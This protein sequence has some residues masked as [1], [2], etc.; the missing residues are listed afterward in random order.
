[1]IEEFERARI[2]EATGKIVGPEGF[3]RGL[4]GAARAEILQLWREFLVLPIPDQPQ[5]GLA[6]PAIWMGQVTNQFVIGG[7]AQIEGLDWGRSFRFQTINATVRAIDLAFVIVR[8]G[9]LT[10]V[11]I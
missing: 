7:F 3:Q 10:I 11:P 1:M 8:V 6:K 5:R 2:I 9:N 4:P